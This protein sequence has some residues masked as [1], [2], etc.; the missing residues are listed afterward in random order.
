M[1]GNEKKAKEWKTIKVTAETKEAL[2]KMGL[3]IGKAVTVLVKQRQAALEK[4]MEEV[5]ALGTDIADILAQ[6]GFFDVKLLGGSITDVKEDD[7]II[8]IHGYFS[9]DIPNDDARER[10][11]ERLTEEK[12]GMKK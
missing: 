5:E 9:I 7:T 1:D 8:T 3:G 6:S 2:E 12:V 11:I 10:I 4:K